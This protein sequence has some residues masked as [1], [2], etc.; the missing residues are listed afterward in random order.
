VLLDSTVTLTRRNKSVISNVAQKSPTSGM[1]KDFTDESVVGLR[2]H[3]YIRHGLDG[4]MFLADGLWNSS[5]IFLRPTMIV[6]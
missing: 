2:R 3:H 5:R 1:Q 6:L 4:Y